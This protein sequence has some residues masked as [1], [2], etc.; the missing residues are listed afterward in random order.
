[1]TQT[2]YMKDV[3]EE[4]VRRAKIA[5]VSK[6]KTLKQFILEAIEKALQNGGAK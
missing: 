2:V 4:L 6:G 1:M 3:P 5:A